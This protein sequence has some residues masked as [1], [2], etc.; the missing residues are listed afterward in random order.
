[1]HSDKHTSGCT[2]VGIAHNTVGDVS[3]C[4]ECSIVH[5]T[6]SHVTVRLT[7]DAFRS[8]SELV[9]VSQQRLDKAEQAVQATQEPVTPEP[10]PMINTPQRLH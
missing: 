8:L 9:K 5:L 2:H 3:V 7:P 4:N 10:M 6:L 1:M